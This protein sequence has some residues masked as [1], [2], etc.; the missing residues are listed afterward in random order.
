[1]IDIVNASKCLQT[2]SQKAQSPRSVPMDQPNSAQQL[3]KNQ[4]MGISAILVAAGINST[5]FLGCLNLSIRG[6]CQL[7]IC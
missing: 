3:S 5:L 6:L 2:L 1:M 7:V 4:D